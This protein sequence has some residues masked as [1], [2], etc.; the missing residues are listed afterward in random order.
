MISLFFRH[1]HTHTHTRKM[2]SVVILF[3]APATG[4]TTFARSLERA[5]ALFGATIQIR[6]NLRYLDLHHL[7]DILVVMSTWESAYIVV[8]E[9]G[10]MQIATNSIFRV[11]F[12]RDPLAVCPEL[13]DVCVR[14][15]QDF[16]D[17]G[18]RTFSHLRL[19]P[20]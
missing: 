16:T 13:H 5:A 12:T 2:V 1:A 7:P 6:E 8:H 19:L 3:G 20:H 17:A 10:Q 18:I 15:P 14:G 4:K 11:W 9:L